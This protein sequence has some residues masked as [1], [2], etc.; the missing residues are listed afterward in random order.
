VIDEDA[1]RV[2]LRPHGT[3]AYEDALVDRLKKR[4][5]HVDP[6][7]LSHASDANAPD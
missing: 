5:A 6:V 4:F 1:T 2:Q 7:I 3:V